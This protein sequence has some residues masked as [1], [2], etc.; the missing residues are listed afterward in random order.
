[1]HARAPLSQTSRAFCALSTHFLEQAI[2]LER[3]E[4]GNLR[5]D[6]RLPPFDLPGHRELIIEQIRRPLVLWYLLNERRPRYFRSIRT[7]AHT[8]D[9]SHRNDRLRPCMHNHRTGIQ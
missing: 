9:P 3:W 6:L 4:R 7:R 8:N 2:K 1:M 5:H